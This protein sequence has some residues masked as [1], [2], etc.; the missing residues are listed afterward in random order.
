MPRRCVIN[1]GWAASR[2]P[3]AGAAAAA[4]L[5]SCPRGAR[6]RRGRRLRWRAPLVR[7]ARLL[8]PLLRL[9]RR[10]QRIVGGRHDL[11]PAALVAVEV[12]GEP[13]RHLRPWQQD[14]ARRG[15]EHARALTD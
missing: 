8:A 2:S 10:A 4:A 15:P 9:Q 14:V 3:A 13:R 11:R 1:T 12:E 7:G 5:P 6:T